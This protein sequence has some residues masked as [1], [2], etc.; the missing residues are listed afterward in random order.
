MNQRADKNYFGQL[1][2][3]LQRSIILLSC[4][5][6]LSLWAYSCNSQKAERNE[7]VDKSKQK[8]NYILDQWAANFL[9][10]VGTDYSIS[11]NFRIPGEDI[12]YNITIKNQNYRIKDQMDNQASFTFKSSLEHYNK[13]FRG[14]M[15]AFTSIGR[16]KMSDSTP[17]DINFNQ[18]MSADLM[19]DFLFFVQRF[20]NKTAYDKVILDKEHSRIVHGAHAIPIFYRKNKNLGVRSAWYQIEKGQQVNEPGDTNPFPQYFI[21]TKGRGYAK[22]GADTIKVKKD[23]AY[24]IAPGADHVFWNDVKNPMELIFLAWGKGA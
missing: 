18:P 8:L 21:I 16:S 5:A 17:L 9:N 2:S 13:I 4:A 14:E 6:I 23:E 1:V 15:T 24:Y 22:I 19:N 20:F 11:V 3:N 7:Q 12:E 10:K